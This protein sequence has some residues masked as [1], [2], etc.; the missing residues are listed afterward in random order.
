MPIFAKTIS[1]IAGLSTVLC[2]SSA[3]MAFAGEL[4]V[5]I[6]GNGRALVDDTRNI[7]FSKGEQSIE[8]P[9]VSSQIQAETATFVA[10]GI[11]ILE[12]NFDFDLLTPTK[13]MEKAVGS[14]VELVRTNP[15]TGMEKRERAKVLSVN[16]GVVVQIGRKIEVLRDDNIPTRVVFDS[17]PENLRA[18]PTLSV[19]VDSEKAGLREANLTYLTSGLNWRADYVAVFNEETETMDL[20][21]WATLTNNTKT[22]FEEANVAVIAGSVNSANGRGGY[23]NQYNQRQNN[24]RGAGTEQS[25]QERVGDNYLYPLPGKITVKSSQT[26]QVGIL[27]AQSVPASKVYEYHASGFNSINQPQ[28]ADVRIAFSNSRD[29]GLGTALPQG[30][31]RVYTKDASE[32][33][34]FIGED[35][36]GHIPGGS[37][38]SLKI[39]DAFDVK[40]KSKVVSNREI[41]RR[42]REMEM[43]YEITNATAKA[44]TVYLRQNMS[45]YGSYK[46]LSESSPSE[47]TS[48]YG[49]VWPVK[50]AAEGKATLTFKV[51]HKTRW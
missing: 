6:Y 38:M 4:S 49:Y 51:Q 44:T 26:K 33:S 15:G 25:P 22:T 9:G 43:S 14:Y 21:G 24:F 27:D 35:R 46:I 10:D 31:F 19:E 36:I 39:G 16:N 47:K 8:L 17:L 37:N 34:Q 42:V 45:S 1:H 41:S 28:S 13:L 40:V 23:N 30:V 32:N 12:Q 18:N 48:A 50:V 3:P 2:L 5:T 7:R 20:Q 29:K 11:S